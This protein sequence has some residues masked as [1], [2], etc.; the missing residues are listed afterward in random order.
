MILNNVDHISATHPTNQ[1]IQNYI[2]LDAPCP[3]SIV[4]YNEVHTS[5]YRQYNNSDC[6]ERH[7][8]IQAFIMVHYGMGHI[9]GKGALCKHVDT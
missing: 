3:Y 7:C 2:D 8:Q 1:C 6:I 5:T 4:Y 9:G